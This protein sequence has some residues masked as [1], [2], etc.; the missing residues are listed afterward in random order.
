[1]R[2]TQKEVFLSHGCFSIVP[3]CFFLVV[4]VSTRAVFAGSANNTSHDFPED[5]I[6][7]LVS[8]IFFHKC[9]IGFFYY[10]RWSLYK[11]KQR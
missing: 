11:I 6:K 1:M 8:F 7:L 3:F 4:G 2:M 5:Q 10:H 9:V